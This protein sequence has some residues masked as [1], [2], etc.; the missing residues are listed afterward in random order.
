MHTSFFHASQP[1]VVFHL[2]RD[3]EVKGADD[4]V[5]NVDEFEF[6]YFK[7]S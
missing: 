6:D 1:A 7:L 5:W 4:G 3:A 2:G